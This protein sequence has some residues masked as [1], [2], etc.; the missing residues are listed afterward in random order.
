[1][2]QPAWNPRIEL[3][4]PVRAW[5]GDDELDLGSAR[6]RAVFAM[7]A[8]RAGRTVS[9]HE[10][11][12]GVWGED[13]PATVEGSLY[14]YVSGLR[15][16]LDPTRALWSGGDVLASVGAGYSL[17]VEPDVL[18]VHLFTE[19][20]ASAAGHS[21]RGDH[22]AAADCL[23]SALELWRG[24]ALSGLA[25]PFADST[26]AQLGELRVAT[27]EQLA[28]ANLALGGHAEVVADLTGLVDEHPLREGLRGLLM[29]A[30]HRS[31]RS[32]DAM[33]SYRGA[34]RMMVDE[35]GIEPGA[36]LR[37]LHDRILANDPSLMPSPA[38]VASVRAPT[39]VVA[40]AVP[41]A[42]SSFVGREAELA[43]LGTRLQALASGRGG[44]VWIEGEPGIGKSG[45]VAAALSTVDSVG[46][47]VLWGAADELSARS[48]L[49][50]LL[51]CLLVE[52][53]SPDERRAR[54]A[55]SLRVDTASVPHSWS[56]SDP[57]LAAI[58]RV[59]TLVEQLCADG[60]VVIVVDDMHWGDDASLTLWQ[61]LT[62]ATAR[63]PLLL[64][65]AS[66]PAPR[67]P[68][69]TRVREAVLGAGGD[70]LALAPLADDEVTELVADVLRAR[71][72]AGLRALTSRAG[73][74]PLYLREVLDA[75][76][77][78]EL[79]ELDGDTAEVSESAHELAPA[80][81]T[82]AITGRLGFLSE[83]TTSVL[84]WAALLGG[85]FD[86]GDLAVVVGTPVTDLMSTLDE[87]IA[88]GVLTDAGPRFVFRHAL[89]RDAI[90][91]TMPVAVRVALHRQVAQLLD[92][93]GADLERVAGQ[94]LAAPTTVDPWMIEWLLTNTPV[95]AG[96]IPTVTVELLARAV[97][98][99]ALRGAARERLT[100]R[101]ARLQFWLGRRPEAEAR[102]VLAMSEDANLIAEMRLIL[103]YLV[104]ARGDAEGAV[105]ALRAVVTDESVPQVWR[106]RHQ[107]L[108]A[109]IERCGLDDI[110]AAERTARGALA[111]ASAECDARA[112]AHALQ[113]LWQVESVERRHASAL[114]YLDRALDAVRD[115]PDLTDL[116][117]SLLDNRV[118]TLQNL[119][120]LDEAEHTLELAGDLLSG[121][122]HIPAAIN[123]YWL[124]RWDSA[125]AELD[126]VVQ[127]GPEITFY[128][129]RQRGAILL[130]HG[131]SALIAVHRDDTEELARH[132]AAA[133]D[134]PLATTADKEHC[135]FLVEAMAVAALRDGRP[136]QALAV[137]LP[138]LDR[139]YAR[140]MLRHQWLPSVVRIA[141]ELGRTDVAHAAWEVC[142]AERDLEATPARAATA[143]LWCQG[144]IENQPH[145]LLLVADRFATTGR[146]L[147]RAF[148][149]EDAAVALAARGWRTPARDAFDEA[150]LTYTEIG[151]A[152]DVRRA[153]SRLAPHG[154]RRDRHVESVARPATEHL[155]PSEL[156][157][158]E[159]VAEGWPVSDIAARMS[160]SDTTVRTRMAE[161][162]RKLGT[163]SRFGVTHNLVRRHHDIRQ[164]TVYF[165]H[166][167][168]NSWRT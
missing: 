65:A 94:L 161:V 119:D 137:Y 102:A 134:F 121:G 15:R 132:L 165:G 12:A 44:G 72:G 133:D 70:L 28:E 67:R 112:Q 2:R 158:A 105:E 61:R 166:C 97:A 142:K 101:L 9:R 114:T 153:E 46:T 45:L 108:Q 109:M 88:A 41:P 125:V 115:N 149:L 126:A 86:L 14:T 147:E 71:P 35:L 51:D 31:G 38:P 99:P 80:T 152:W 168:R 19:L 53:S 52:P 34:R 128:G 7:L 167:G 84:R 39:P 85:E 36:A 98:S 154:I 122:L 40:C 81:M 129:L 18:D 139:K 95:I 156:R 59:R 58:D 163:G 162:L 32:A 151:A 37:E 116:R 96:R 48:P 29:L 140:M 50:V 155:S 22:R 123:N 164:L 30:L 33:E 68:E 157:I 24:D 111:R 141:L 83:P 16:A 69:I 78:D 143:A 87:A 93:A 106:A 25:G 124:G 1:M 11:I 62:Q 23:T 60:P 17:R 160:L 20:R 127:D 118:F 64:V 113:N 76:A 54:L 148:V 131:A 145:L 75:L 3:L 89:V 100:A 136:E 103:A 43:V 135:D 26:S 117:L 77:R 56:T 42:P 63:Q 79:V 47:Q 13:A 6:R 144:L 10:L 104:Y 55:E 91:A 138:I 8:M 5:Q 73:G 120:R 82:A 27:R 130:L 90:Y 74:N 57:V 110:E 66:R 92:A 146:V 21:E 107:S 4:G 159:L 150:V 49:R